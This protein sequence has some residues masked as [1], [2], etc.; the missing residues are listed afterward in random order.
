LRIVSCHLGAGASLCAIADGCS[1]D[2]TMG[3]TPLEGLA[4]ATRSGSVDPGMLLWLMEREELSPREMSGALE[5]HSG[6]LALAGSADMREIVERVAAEVESDDGRSARLALD[7]YVHHLRAGI[8][9]MV[10]ALGGLDALVFTGGVGEHSAVVRE[11]TA[12]GLAFLGVGLDSAR[13][14]AAQG[15]A[16]ISPSAGAVRTLVITAREDLEIAGQVRALLGR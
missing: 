9:A 8:A 12:A 13:N 7:V 4:M 11:Q 16:E 1:R 3:F 2:T 6:L 10:A 14:E 15:D 5:H